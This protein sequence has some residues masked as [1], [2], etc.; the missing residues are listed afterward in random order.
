MNAAA[1]I[2]VLRK[3][4]ISDLTPKVQAAL[5]DAVLTPDVGTGGVYDIEGMSGKRYRYFINRLVRG[6][7]NPRY[8]EVGSWRGSTLCSAIHGNTLTAVAIDN[9]S[10]F[11]GP[12]D[13]F[14]KNVQTFTNPSAKVFF[15]ESDFRKVDF[16]KFDEKF[17]VYLFDGPHEAQDQFDGLAMALPTLEDEF[18]FIVDDWNWER[19]RTGTFA[20]IRKC[21]LGVTF[22]AEIRSTLDNTQPVINGKASDWHNG[23]FIAVLTKP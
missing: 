17:N 14:E 9:W 1:S 22:V 8:L 16:T 5:D 2:S 11:G 23:Y 20:A 4:N 18:V 7:S 6:L 19:V 12:K 10:Q 15:V 13:E 21:N 3:N